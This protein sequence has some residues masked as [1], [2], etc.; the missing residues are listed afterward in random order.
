MFPLHKSQL[1]S[2]TVFSQHNVQGTLPQ[3]IR[4]PLVN[5]SD[6][7]VNRIFSTTVT[8]SSSQ[9]EINIVLRS[10]KEEETLLTAA[11]S[12]NIISEAN[13][14]SGN[15]KVKAKIDSL[16][17]KMCC[18]VGLT[19]SSRFLPDFYEGLKGLTKIAAL[20]R[21][22]R[23]QEVALNALRDT[24][25]LMRENLDDSSHIKCAGKL[26]EMAKILSDVWADSSITQTYNNSVKA[27]MLF[28][29]GELADLYIRY[30]DKK[31]VGSVDANF[32]TA[33]QE[34][35]KII[36][37][38]LLK[39]ELVAHDVE[40]TLAAEYALSAISL[41][42]T[43]E[44]T[45]I[46]ALS[47]L[48]SLV[49]LGFAVKNI[50]YDTAIMKFTEIFKKIG[51]NK[52][53]TWFPAAYVLH[54]M[55]ADI[56]STHP[57]SSQRN[58]EATF[59]SFLNEIK[60]L[61]TR[62][63][64]QY[65][66]TA[67]DL[68]AK[69]AFDSPSPTIASRAAMELMI[70]KKSLT[71]CSSAPSQ[72]H[73]AV[74]QK[75]SGFARQGVVKAIIN[76]EAMLDDLER[77]QAFAADRELKIFDARTELARKTVKNSLITTYDSSDICSISFKKIIEKFQQLKL[78]QSAQR[79]EK[80]SF[81]EDALYEWIGHFPSERYPEPPNAYAD[82][83]YERSS[84]H[85][86]HEQPVVHPLTPIEIFRHRTYE[87][88]KKN[89]DALY[90]NAK[91]TAF[92]NFEKFKKN[93][94]TMP[95]NADGEEMKLEDWHFFLDCSDKELLD[96]KI[97]PKE[98]ARFV[99]LGIEYRLFNDKSVN[100]MALADLIFNYNIASTKLLLALCDNHNGDVMLL[101]NA[102][103]HSYKNIADFGINLTLSNSKEQDLLLF[104]FKSVF[105]RFVVDQSLYLKKELLP[106]IE[107]MHTA[108]AQSITK[109][110]YLDKS[111]LIMF[112]YL[113][114]KTNMRIN[115]VIIG[116]LELIQKKIV[117]SNEITDSDSE[118]FQLVEILMANGKYFSLELRAIHNRYCRTIYSSDAL[119]LIINSSKNEKLVAVI[120][121][122][123]PMPTTPKVTWKKLIT[124]QSEPK[125]IY[126]CYDFDVGTHNF[127][128]WCQFDCLD[129]YYDVM[130]SKVFESKKNAPNSEILQTERPLTLTW[131]KFETILKDKNSI[132][133]HSEFN[134]NGQTIKDYSLF[135]CPSL[136]NGMKSAIFNLR[137]NEISPP[138]E[139]HEL[140]KVVTKNE[141]LKPLTVPVDGN[142]PIFA[143]TF[144]LR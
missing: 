6:S 46:E 91:E 82:H 107:A 127:T 106:F 76:A 102:V 34:T 138:R 67:I 64:W 108:L 128:G 18:L 129:E 36:K 75:R 4:S 61:R 124:Y 123:S 42:M 54:H 90:W 45:L 141:P 41:L 53:S 72:Q 93:T 97:T 56:L 44:S 48:N 140:P 60:R 120:A 26:L 65:T 83:H 125:L 105:E 103:L 118:I 113:L 59:D 104:T 71:T 66:A 30:Y 31:V 51:L 13:N 12:D 8:P 87:L 81:H 39:S 142:L 139:T 92:L 29:L 88:R 33:L 134:V 96:K 99:L 3:K 32:K 35:V 116:F 17:W 70:L 109:N 143:T 117:N 2:S 20:I 57:K 101:Q 68:L 85:Q 84:M 49:S 5:F 121:P 28:A 24:L 119:A 144:T 23:Q 11:V 14:S 15:H 126:V 137:K 132:D 62:H 58:S 77:L 38:L 52:V 63:S 111:K 133:V 136:I 40:F 110:E 94:T 89:P 130:K 69:I 19:N 115:S 22:P 7:N 25:F 73:E 135:T 16:T 21:D 114:Y 122:H 79:G 78:L 9:Q 50:D 10:N 86:P 95:R 74:A 98:K 1:R 100:K 47:L 112:T 55:V 37:G 27:K 80:P 131:N 43:N